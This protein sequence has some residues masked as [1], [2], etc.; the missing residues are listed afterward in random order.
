MFGYVNMREAHIC[1]KNIKQQN[2]YSESGV[3]SLN[4]EGG[5]ICPN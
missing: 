2:N 1:I 3:S 5:C 4:W